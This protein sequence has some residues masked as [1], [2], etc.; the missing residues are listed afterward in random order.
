MVVVGVGPLPE[1]VVVVSGVVYRCWGAERMH[2]IL[3]AKIPGMSL[4]LL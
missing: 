3:L 4:R 2:S 1:L